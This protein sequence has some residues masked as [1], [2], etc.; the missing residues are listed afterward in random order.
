MSAIK[1]WSYDWLDEHIEE[2]DNGTATVTLDN[3]NIRKH[4]VSVEAAKDYLLKNEVD[5]AFADMRSSIADAGV[6]AR[7]FGEL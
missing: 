7:K 6:D 1:D 3:S 4:F 2:N 5:E